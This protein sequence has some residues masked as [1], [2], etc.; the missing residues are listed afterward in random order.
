MAIRA[1]LVLARKK[2][3]LG[4][5]EVAKQIGVAKSTY[6]QYESGVRTPSLAVANRL[7]ELFNKDARELFAESKHHESDSTPEVEEAKQ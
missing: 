3:K 6:C 1:N 7:S 2:R 4:Q 5:R